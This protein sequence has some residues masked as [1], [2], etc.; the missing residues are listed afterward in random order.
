MPEKHAYQLYKNEY[1]ENGREK[2]FCFVCMTHTHTNQMGDSNIYSHLKFVSSV[3]EQKKFG[4][5]NVREE[6]Q[7]YQQQDFYDDEEL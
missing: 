5:K 6:S 7:L 1:M 3:N 4:K 2:K